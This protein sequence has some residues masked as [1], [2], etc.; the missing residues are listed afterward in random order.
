MQLVVILSASPSSLS[1]RYACILSAIPGFAAGEAAGL[2][3]PPG[4]RNRWKQPFHAM[5]GML[6]R[7]ALPAVRS[8]GKHAEELGGPEAPVRAVVYSGS[9]AQEALEETNRIVRSADEV[10]HASSFEALEFPPLLR[11]GESS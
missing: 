5:H 7:T 10:Q 8:R 1:Y 3:I 2:R 6:V 4:A 11:I 9:A